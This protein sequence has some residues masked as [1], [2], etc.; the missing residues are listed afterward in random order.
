MK[1]NK[2]KEVV[3]NE[4]RRKLWQAAEDA[5]EPSPFQQQNN[6]LEGDSDSDENLFG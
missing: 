4:A 6:L 5:K 1:D 3:K 2:Q